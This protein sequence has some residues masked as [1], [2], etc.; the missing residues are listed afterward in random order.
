M[1]IKIT[2]E[3]NKD[4]LDL[5]YHILKQ[6]RLSTPTYEKRFGNISGF[7]KKISKALQEIDKNVQK[8][9]EIIFKLSVTTPYKSDDIIQFIMLTGLDI[10]EAEKI[11]TSL[12]NCGISNLVDINNIIKLGYTNFVK[13][14]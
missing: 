5:I 2:M 9:H 6:E 7:F 11:I 1:K 10:N 3:L 4:E 12:C 8:D 14:K 13:I